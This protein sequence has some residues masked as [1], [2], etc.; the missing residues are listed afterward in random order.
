[1]L[2]VGEED[3]RCSSASIYKQLYHWEPMYKRSWQND[4]L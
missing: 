3:I 2:D 1:V 4:V